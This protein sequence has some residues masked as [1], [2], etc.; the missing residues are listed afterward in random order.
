MGIARCRRCLKHKFDVG[1]QFSTYPKSPGARTLPSACPP[2]LLRCRAA[3]L[4]ALLAPSPAPGRGAWN[5]IHGRRRGCYEDGGLRIPG[6]TDARGVGGAG[7][8]AGGWGVADPQHH[9][10]ARRGGAGEG[11]R[12]W[13][14]ADPR[15]HGRAWRWGSRGGEGAGWQLCAGDPGIVDAIRMEAGAW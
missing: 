13:G 15:H 7:E 1:F 5:G 4:H 12:G 6:I 2:C 9:G 11:S 8:G 10:R 14:V 3:A